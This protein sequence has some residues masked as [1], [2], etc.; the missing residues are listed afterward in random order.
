MSWLL[1]A[2][3]DLSSAVVDFIPILVP[4]DL[5]ERNHVLLL[6]CEYVPLVVARGLAIFGAMQQQK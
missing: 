4:P 2:T 5:V 1:A 6:T 3:G